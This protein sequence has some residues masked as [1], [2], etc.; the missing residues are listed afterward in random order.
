MSGIFG[1][2]VFARASGTSLAGGRFGAP[3][4]RARQRA[5][6]DWTDFFTGDEEVAGGNS[7]AQPVTDGTLITGT[8]GPAATHSPG[9]M[10][11]FGS[12]LK[13]YIDD[14]KNPSSFCILDPKIN[15]TCPPNQIYDPV[16]L[17][18]VPY[19]PDLIEGAQPQTGVICPYGTKPVGQACVSLVTPTPSTGG[20]T[21]TI[22]APPGPTP[23][24]NINALSGSGVPTWAILLGVVGAVGLVG[25]AVV[26][27]KK[28][29]QK[30][31]R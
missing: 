27:K 3:P 7:T 20:G 2:S 15:Y 19:K 4:G 31:R 1:D 9:A 18:C 10:P 17:G 29:G 25:A 16:K 24:P 5:M 12:C 6:G 22:T 14:P 23:N 28:A 8:A 26:A 30:G 13:P 21:K 11:K